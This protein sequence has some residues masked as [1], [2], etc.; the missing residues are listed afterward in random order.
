MPRIQPTA[1]SIKKVAFFAFSTS[2][3]HEPAYNHTLVFDNAV[4]NIGNA[5]NTQSGKFIAPNYGL[6]VFTWTI[7]IWGP[8]Y[9]TTELLVDNSVVHAVFL[10]PG[11]VIDGTVNGTAVVHVTKDRKSL[12]ELALVSINITLLVTVMAVHHL[13]AGM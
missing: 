13:L 4:T 1:K 8:S 11:N 12:L 6:Y 7:S 5:Y 2:M 10:N 3:I 9:H